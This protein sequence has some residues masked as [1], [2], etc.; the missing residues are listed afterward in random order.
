MDYIFV[1]TESIAGTIH[2]KGPVSGKM[3]EVKPSGSWILD[4][5]E[6]D[7]KKLYLG[8]KRYCRRSKSMVDL[9]VF[10]TTPSSRQM[11]LIPN[12]GN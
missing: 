12:G 2:I 3:W 6:R 11:M 9:L 5:F 4:E 7:D 1:A 8:L 10:L